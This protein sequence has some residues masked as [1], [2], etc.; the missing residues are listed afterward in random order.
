MS[1]GSTYMFYI[2]SS[3]GYGAQNKS[4]IPPNSTLIFQVDLISIQGK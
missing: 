4:G 1:V 3:L 2:P